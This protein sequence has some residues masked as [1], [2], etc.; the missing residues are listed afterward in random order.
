MT[1]AEIEKNYVDYPTIA[2]ECGAS[3]Y[4]VGNW[5]RYHKYFETEHVFGK[6]LVHRDQY[7][8]FKREHP[9]LIKAPVTA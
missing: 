2:R 5:A 8:K 4:Q 1:L 7:E 6:P 3:P 9:E